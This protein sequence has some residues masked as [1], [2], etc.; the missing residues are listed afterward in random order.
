MVDTVLNEP[1][2]L[3]MIS[4]ILIIVNL[5]V[6]V[7]ALVMSNWNWGQFVLNLIDLQLT[8]GIYF[9]GWAMAKNQ[10]D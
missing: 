10:I 6:D 7:R 4:L 2:F 8:C 1:L 3:A 9:I 5:F